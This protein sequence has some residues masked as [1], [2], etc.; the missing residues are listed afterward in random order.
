MG[1]SATKLN[2][3]FDDWLSKAYNYV[4]KE[5]ELLENSID[6]ASINDEL[7]SQKDEEENQEPQE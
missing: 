7:E 2:R 3:K 5:E 6:I 4:F 1:N